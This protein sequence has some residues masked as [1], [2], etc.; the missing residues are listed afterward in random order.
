MV[1][2]NQDENM[3]IKNQKGGDGVLDINNELKNKYIDDSIASQFSPELKEVWDKIFECRAEIESIL[4][5]KTSIMGKGFWKNE[6]DILIAAYVLARAC[7]SGEANLYSF[8]TDFSLDKDVLELI[9]ETNIEK[10]WDELLGLTYKYDKRIFFL[11][12]N[13]RDLSDPMTTPEGLAVL[14]EKLLNVKPQE[15]FAD[16]CC[17]AGSVVS[18]IKRSM[19]QI[20]AYGFDIDRNA[21]AIAK[22]DNEMSKTEIFFEKKDIFELGLEKEDRKKFDKIFANYPFGTRLRE[23]KAGKIYLEELRKRIPSISKATSSDWLYN[24]LVV[25]LLSENGKAVGIMTN[26][27]TWNMIDAPIRKYFVENGLIETVIALPAKLFATTNIATSM[28]VFSHNNQTIRLVDATELYVAERRVNKL[29]EEFIDRI[30]ES[31]DDDEIS[32]CIN[33]E[34]L[35]ENDYVLNVNRYQNNQ[36]NIENGQPF[37]NVI[38]RITRGASMKA[39]ELDDISSQIPTNM[40]YLMLS[41]IQNGFIDSDLP[42]LKTID[43]KNEKYC[44]SDRCLILSKNGYPYKVAVAEVKEGQKIMGNGNLYIV[45]LDEEKIDPYYL[46]A[47]LSSEQGTAALKSITVGATI[48]NIGIEQLKK[49]IIPVPSLAKQKKISESYQILKDEIIM[50]QLKLE[51]AKNRMS[52]VFEEGG[53]ENA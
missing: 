43:K 52:Q 20:N 37:E 6:G 35:R 10:Y 5:S 22:I 46:A 19:P 34:T 7:E 18:A 50:L 45:E 8:K 17:G 16:L 31:M 9:K 12:S 13:L 47:F 26:G 28:I 32:M 29:T 4:R 39:K 41:N 30:L 1:I 2:Y 25:D 24:M 11:V 48:P 21:I 15:Y 27:S 38:K 36:A 42:Y 44:L 23:L 53:G 3:V 49:L 51:K 33:I 40:Q 14:A